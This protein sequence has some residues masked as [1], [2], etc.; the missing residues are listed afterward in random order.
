[1][2]AQ[3]MNN[4][5]YRILRNSGDEVVKIDYITAALTL[6][7]DG[8]FKGS[9]KWNTYRMPRGTRVRVK[10]GYA[11]NRWY[12]E[13]TTMSGEPIVDIWAEGPM[14]DWWNRANIVTALEVLQAYELECIRAQRIDGYCPQPPRGLLLNCS[15]D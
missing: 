11:G 12:C 5:I 8:Q 14:G 13:I 9:K 1:M 6:E 3:V 7:L 15:R 4:L 10:E 2:D